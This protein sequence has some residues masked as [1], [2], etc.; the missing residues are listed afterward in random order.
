M[1]RRFDST[2][3]AD[4]WI[5]VYQCFFPLRGKADS[6]FL[7]VLSAYTASENV[8]INNMLRSGNIMEKDDYFYPR[9]QILLEY[10]P[11]YKVPCNIICYRYLHSRAWNALL[12]NKK[13]HKNMIV[14]DKAFMSTSLLSNAVESY[15]KNRNLEICLE[16][17]IPAGTIGTYVGHMNELAEYEILLA[18][19]TSF[20]IDS[21]CFPWQK[22]FKCT[23]VKKN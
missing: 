21:R 22:R 5:K 1:Y 8:P 17:S 9:L 14:T 13:P 10:F 6:A 2:F 16:I 12:E 19:E 18:P 3:A 23:V 4:L 11:K 20:R 7:D 15:K